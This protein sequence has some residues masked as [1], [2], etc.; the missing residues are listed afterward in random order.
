[1]SIPVTTIPIEFL[2]LIGYAICLA[3]IA[4]VLEMAASF[5]QRRSM[6]FNTV[7]F[8]YHPERDIWRCPQ[9]QH[10]FPIFFDA[11]Q[12]KTVYRAPA[13]ACNSC[14]SKAACTDSSRGREITRMEE[15]S[16]EFGMRRFHRVM[17]IT[18]LTLASVLILV[19][20]AF[21][22]T[23]WQRAALTTVLLAF[24]STIHKISREI[25]S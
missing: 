9:D 19:D 23:F 7:G 3:L 1:M 22:R 8:I 2:L 13:S 6:N 4:M 25:A 5:A 21:A 14:P 10:L 16:I 11:N 15:A 18:L 24:G 12:K 20:F 17:S